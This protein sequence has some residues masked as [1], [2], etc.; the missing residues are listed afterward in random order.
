MGITF[1]TARGTR[2]PFKIYQF[3]NESGNIDKLQADISSSHFVFGKTTDDVVDVGAESVLW[4]SQDNLIGYSGD[5]ISGNVQKTVFLDNVN[6]RPYISFDDGV[7]W[8]VRQP[9]NEVAEV[10]DIFEFYVSPQRIEPTWE[11]LQTEVRTRGGWEIQ[12]WGTRL[13]EVQV[14]CKTGG[15]NKIDGEFMDLSQDITQSDAWKRVSKLRQIFL[16]DHARRNTQS[17]YKLGMYYMDKM[18]IGFFTRFSGPT[19]DVEKPYI[20]DFSFA[21]KVEVEL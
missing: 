11:K 13:T 20:L 10:K 6:G 12:H 8:Y 3:N 19:L 9:I 14:T 7:K 18:F 16:E 5:P 2:V 15:M 17:S 21:F 1:G 4:V